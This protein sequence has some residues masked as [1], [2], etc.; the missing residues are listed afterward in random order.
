MFTTTTKTTTSTV[1]RLGQTT[2]AAT[3]S[4]KARIAGLLTQACPSEAERE[5]AKKKVFTLYKHNLG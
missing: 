3:R 5:L 2:N 4:A 1:P